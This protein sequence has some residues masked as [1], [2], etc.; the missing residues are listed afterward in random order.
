MF[1]LIPFC[2]T[3]TVGMGG[4]ITAAGNNRS[5]LLGGDVDGAG[6]VPRSTLELWTFLIEGS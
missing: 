5:L 3:V 2:F 1:A 6:G 4:P